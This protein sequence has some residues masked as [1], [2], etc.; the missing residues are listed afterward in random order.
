[1]VLNR[2]GEGLKE[3]IRKIMRAGYIDKA[4]LDE[5]VKDIQRS[6]IAGDVN[7]QLVFE[8]T[9]KIRDRAINE[10]PAPG[11]TAKE[12]VIKV[13]Y[14]ELV[15]FVGKG[16]PLPLKPTKILL[17]GLFGSGKT[18][19]AGKIAK[20][21]INR[22]LKPGLICCDVIRPAAFEQLQ[23]LA[24]QLHVPFFGIKGENDA[25]TVLREGLEIMGKKADVIIID[26]SGRDA[27]DQDMIRELISLNDIAKP[28]ER[29]LVIPADLGQAAK[30]Q[31][32]AFQNAIKITG[33]I[34]TKMD[35][36]AK[37]GG[38]LTACAVAHAPVRAI[39]IGEKIDAFEE[40][41]PERF[42]SRLI[43]FGD[44]QSLLEKAKE[45]ME[46]E[47]AKKIVDHFMKG[48]FTLEDM[49]EQITSMQKMGPLGNIMGMIPGFGMA[50]PK[51]IDLSKQE[52]KIKRWGY[53]I[54]S[55][56]R[57]ERMEPE[58]INSERIRRISR[59]SGVPECEIR[60]LLKTYEQ[61]K[62]LMKTVSGGGMK[63]GMLAQLMKKFKGF[64]A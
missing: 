57:Q 51:G 11:M 17:C 7:V 54:Q 55:M 32:E 22:G 64:R 60:E 59:G 43:G 16:V 25:S 8:L 24:A 56:T 4:V 33:V 12:H 44:L 48:K 37:A 35:G 62:R 40:F 19:T 47:K 13:V 27:L 15:K 20:F 50:L 14:E 38:A 9:N 31:T 2:L 42:I 1:M 26:S 23:Q 3:A 63:R 41:N 5:L 45:A 10:K 46:P 34:I 6:L 36:T 29:I 39:G 28:E 18:T 61:T 21:Y 58:I 53:A 52:E 30:E 49:Y